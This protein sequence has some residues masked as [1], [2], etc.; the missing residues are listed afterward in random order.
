[1]TGFC[2]L[3][4]GGLGPN[5]GRALGQHLRGIAYAYEGRHAE[6]E[7]AFLR[8]VEMEPDMAGSYVELGL[9]YACRG[10]YARMVEALRRAVATGEAGVRAYLGER[11][12]GD[13]LPGRMSDASRRAPE[14]GGGG[15]EVT[16]LLLDSAVSHIAAGRDEEAAQV[17]EPMVGQAEVTP[18][19]S[20][21]LVLCCLLSGE[22]VETSDEGIRR[23]M[24]PSDASGG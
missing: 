13:V 11:P 3:G 14:G 16:A 22:Q 17:L 12:L 8:A 18:A 1:M 24:V 4:Q 5:V 2:G 19:A 6:A 20:A 23:G 15:R 7:E 10:E 9:V 21:L